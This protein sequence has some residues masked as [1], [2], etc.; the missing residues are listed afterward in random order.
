MKS[1]APNSLR[2]LYGLR[3]ND[4]LC[5][6]FTK[7]EFEED[8]K[9]LSKAKCPLTIEVWRALPTSNKD[10][11]TSI[12]MPKSKSGGNPFNPGAKKIAQYNNEN[13]KRKGE[14]NASCDAALNKNDEEDKREQG[15][16]DASGDAAHNKNDKEDKREREKDASGDAAHNKSDATSGEAAH[17]KNDEEYKREG[18]K[19][20]SGNPGHNK[21]DMEAHNKNDEEDKREREKDA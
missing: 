11:I 8:A 2:E 19:D 14:K 12:K 5:K 4:I 17:N 20:A 7:R 3:N 21:S 18:G 6:P 9:S 16:K 1:V 10:L 15:E 13:K